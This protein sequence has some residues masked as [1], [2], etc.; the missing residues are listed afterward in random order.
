[1]KKFKRVFVIVMDS[2]GIGEMPDASKFGD[3]N[4][5]TWM[6]VSEAC[7]GLKIPQMNAL[8]LGD[9]APVLGTQKVNHPHSYCAILKEASNGKD[10]MTGHWK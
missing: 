9:L 10:T 8:G 2:V 5:N 4:V 7:G 1:M 6:H 3:H